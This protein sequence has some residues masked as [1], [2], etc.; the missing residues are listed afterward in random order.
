MKVSRTVEASFDESLRGL[1]QDCP[2]FNRQIVLSSELIGF[3]F[4]LNFRSLC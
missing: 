4:L 3:V 1:L 2:G